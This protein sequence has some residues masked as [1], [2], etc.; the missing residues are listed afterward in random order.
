[1]VLNTETLDCES[2]VLATRLLS[3]MS[4]MFGS[5]IFDLN[6]YFDYIVI[7]VYFSLHPLWIC[8]PARCV[9]FTVPSGRK[10][11]LF[12]LL[13]QMYTSG[14]TFIKNIKPFI[15]HYTSISW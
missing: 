6:P 2:S 5:I 4:L 12:F 13:E 7:F 3:L 9:Y 15:F 10:A 8:Y 14:S 11:A 1:M